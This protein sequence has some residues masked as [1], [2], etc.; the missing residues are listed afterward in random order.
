MGQNTRSIGRFEGYYLEDCNCIFCKNYQGKKRGCKLDK[1]CC[2][3]EKLD[4][5]ANGRIERKKGSA[6]WDG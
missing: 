4:A 3:D 5:I 6:A 1:C 2:D